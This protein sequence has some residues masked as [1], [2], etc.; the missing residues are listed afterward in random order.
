VELIAQMNGFSEE[1]TL[2]L[3]AQIKDW[4]VRLGDRE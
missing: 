4:Q 1:Q 2:S 3:V